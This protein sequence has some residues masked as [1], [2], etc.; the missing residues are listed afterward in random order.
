MKATKMKIHM[1]NRSVTQPRGIV[2]DILVKIGKFVFPIDFVVLDMKEDTDVPIILGRPFL[3]TAGA[4][5][6]IRESKLTLRVGDEQEVFGI[7]ND[8]QEDKEEV[9]TINEENELEELE[10]LMEEEIKVV[11]QAKRTKPRASVPYLIEVIAYKNPPSWVS[12]EDEEMTSD[13]EE[14]TSKETRPE[15]K[16]EGNAMESKEHTKG[17]KRKHEEDGKTKKENS[18]KAYKRRVQ[19]YKRRFKEQKILV[20]DSSEES[21]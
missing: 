21:T 7:R 8:F 19:A 16:E 11:H 13:E 15:V 9:F 14:V 3:N 17:T 1:A 12:E 20:V 18:K 2:E 4:L 6:D 5:V 10:K